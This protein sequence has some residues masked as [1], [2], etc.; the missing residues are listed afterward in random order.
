[1][2]K[3]YLY[4]ANL[5]QVEKFCKKREDCNGCELY[6]THGLCAKDIIPKDT[7]DMKGLFRY[8]LRE[9]EI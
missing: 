3:I 6:F 4:E 7:N 9:I 5:E 1:M 2:S 8:L